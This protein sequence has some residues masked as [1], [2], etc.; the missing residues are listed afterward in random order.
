MPSTKIPADRPRARAAFAALAVPFVT[1]LWV[2]EWALA[3]AKWWVYGWWHPPAP[4]S[5]Q[6]QYAWSTLSARALP[7]DGD[8]PTLHHPRIAPDQWESLG[9]HMLVSTCCDRA[10]SRMF[11]DR[12]PRCSHCGAVLKLP[13]WAGTSAERYMDARRLGADHSLA[14]QS[15]GTDKVA[16]ERA[17]EEYEHSHG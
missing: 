14:G 11:F 8:L 13:L 7:S 15:F 12:A 5:H 17:R 10:W 9:E 3:P 6:V 1:L 4:L 16:A 2:L